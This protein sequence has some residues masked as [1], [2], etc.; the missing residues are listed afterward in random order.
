MGKG[1][2]LNQKLGKRISR[3]LDLLKSQLASQR[4]PASRLSSSRL[5][6][7]GVSREAKPGV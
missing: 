5:P 4:Q 6:K 7:K 1:R 2:F 3:K